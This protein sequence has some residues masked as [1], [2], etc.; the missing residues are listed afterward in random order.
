MPASAPGGVSQ[1][2]LQRRWF[3]DHRKDA[4]QL[5]KLLTN[6]IEDA[7]DMATRSAK[8]YMRIRPFAFYGVS[9]CNT[10]EQ[11][12]LAKNGSYPSGHASHRLGLPPGAG[13]RSTRSSKQKF[14]ARLWALGEPE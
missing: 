2:L 7:G 6:M 14:E 9:T 10:T 1:H 13:R 4:P 11:D 3:A 8:K 12:K 5:H